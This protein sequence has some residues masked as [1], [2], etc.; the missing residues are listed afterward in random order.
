MALVHYKTKNIHFAMLKTLFKER[1]AEVRILVCHLLMFRNKS[2]D[3][4]IV[5]L[6]PGL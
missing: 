1:T 5:N 4:C 3:V 2:S 6:K